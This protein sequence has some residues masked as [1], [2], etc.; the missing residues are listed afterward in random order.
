LD[1][2]AAKPQQFHDT[3]AVFQTRLHEANG[4]QLGDLLSSTAMITGGLW[5]YSRLYESGFRILPLSRNKVV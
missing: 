2:I 3:R 4:G 5:Y 1:P